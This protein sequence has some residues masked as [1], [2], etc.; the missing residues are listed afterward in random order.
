MMYMSGAYDVLFLPDFLSN[1]LQILAL[2]S[3]GIEF[4]CLG[5]YLG[6]FS[7]TPSLLFF[8]IYLEFSGSLCMYRSR[9]DDNSVS[10]LGR[11]IN[12]LNA[13]F[14]NKIAFA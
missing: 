8:R 3:L 11:L 4:Y 12:P 13:R 6:T 14:D 2:W 7:R 10:R 1:Q 9:F 5:P